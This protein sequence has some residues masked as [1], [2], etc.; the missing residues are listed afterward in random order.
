MKKILML[1]FLMAGT[2]KGFSQSLEDINKLMEKQQFL[3]AKAAIDKYL[4]DPKNASSAE[5]YYYKGRIYNSLSR[6]AAT[7]KSDAYNY[8][9]TAFNAFKQNQQLDKLDFRMKSEFYNSYLDLYA[10]FYDLGAAQFNDKD[11][12]EAY[13]SFLKANEVENFILSR[14]YTY[15]QIKMSSLDTSLIINI[16]TAALQAHDSVNAVLNYRKISDAGITGKNYE[17][18][19][20]FLVAYYKV[21]QDETNFANTLA[22]GKIAYPQSNYWNEMEMDKLTQSGDKKALFARYEEQYVKDPANFANNYNY[23]VEMYNNIYKDLKDTAPASKDKLTALLKNAILH[24]TTIDATSLIANHLFNAAADLSTS[25]A[26]IKGAKPDDIKKK[27]ELNALAIAKMD[28]TIPYAE[29]VLKYYDA[30]PKLTTR[31]KANY[32]TIAGFLSD[33]YSAKGNAKK[34]AEYDKIRASVKF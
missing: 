4:A 25:A 26:L 14:K 10:G 7:P 11:F 17:Q 24:D 2:C 16:A 8:K 9:M 27:K 19:Y 15:D 12:K 23:A 31:Q 13:N 33:I 1:A 21:K 29:K 22:K 6:V 30:L 3:P 34:S 5:G 28:E 20:Q 18:I 32:L